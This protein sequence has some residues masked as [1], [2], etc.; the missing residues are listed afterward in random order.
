MEGC[1]EEVPF[2]DE[3]GEPVTV[4]EGFDSG[5]GVDDAGG[6]DEDH[7]QWAAFE[8]CGSSEDGGVDLA[9]VG[10]AFDGNVEDGERFLRGVLYFF[11]EQDGSGAGAEGGSGFDER[12]QGIEEAVA[13]EELQEGGGFATGDDEAVEVLQLGWGADELGVDAEGFEGLGVCFE[14]ALQGKD[15]DGDGFGHDWFNGI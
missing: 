7:L 11:G 8:L 4:G 13:L 10:I 14:C 9:A 12:L 6:A 5:A 15:A 2:A 3:D 1:G